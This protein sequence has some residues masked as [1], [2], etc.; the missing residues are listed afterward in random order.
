[1][2]AVLKRYARHCARQPGRGPPFPLLNLH[3]RGLS[4]ATILLALC[5][6]PQPLYTLA[7]CF[8]RHTSA[9]REPSVRLCGNPRELHYPHEEPG[10]RFLS[11]DYTYQEDP[12]Y[13]KVISTV[14]EQYAS[15]GSE[16]AFALLRLL[17]TGGM[18][19]RS[20]PVPVQFA[21]QQGWRQRQHYRLLTWV[22]ECVGAD[23][24]GLE[25]GDMEGDKPLSLPHPGE[26]MGRWAPLPFVTLCVAHGVAAEPLLSGL[27]QRP[28]P[29]MVLITQML[30]G[31]PGSLARS[32]DN[33]PRGPGVHGAPRPDVDWA[34]GRMLRHAAATGSIE[35]VDLLL[36]NNATKTAAAVH[37]PD[38]P[39]HVALRII[40]ATGGKIPRGPFVD[41]ICASVL[42]DSGDK[43]I[44]EVVEQLIGMGAE[45]A[46]LVLAAA[47][48]GSGPA[49]QY[50][51]EEKG[52][53]ST[54]LYT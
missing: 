30:S 20:R 42:R 5:D 28:D 11:T 48:L 50:L 22:L 44:G 40:S 7:L 39:A 41:T 38:T 45:P 16:A 47:S 6:Q 2:Q 37:S 15:T 1:M 49:M 3:E 23:A 13:V 33:G 53:V 46:D 9:F 51:V 14:Y 54:T 36:A 27:C 31:Q 12:D 32:D 8:V 43:P 17:V 29:P 21:W 10:L 4:A 18:Q 25:C 24:L 34:G 35:L 52:Q 19:G 26:V